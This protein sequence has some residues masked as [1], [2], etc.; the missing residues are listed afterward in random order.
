V[1]GTSGSRSRSRLAIG[2]ST[3]GLASPIDGSGGFLSPASFF[4]CC[5]PAAGAAVAGFF[6]LGVA[7]VLCCAVP[8]SLI[9]LVGRWDYYGDQD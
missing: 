6:C 7:R 2:I 3:D 9:C 5:W 8:A 1:G 4:S